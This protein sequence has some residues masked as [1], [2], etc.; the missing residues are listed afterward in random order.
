MKFGFNVPILIDKKNE[1]VCGHGRYFAVQ[2]LKGQLGE[3]LKEP[4]S[5]E[6]KENLEKINKGFIP[7]I[8]LD[9]PEKLAKEFRISDNKIVEYTQWNEKN[10]A[11]EMMELDKKVLG[12]L[13]AE[14]DNLINKEFIEQKTSKLASLPEKEILEG[15]EKKFEVETRPKQIEFICPYCKQ[16]FYLDFNDVVMKIETT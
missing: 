1:I 14:V 9:L 4:M 6:L 13:D 5:E 8:T 3:K 16:K 2:R 11:L 15:L 10:L 12:F 7:I